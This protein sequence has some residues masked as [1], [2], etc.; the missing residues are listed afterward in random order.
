MFLEGQGT[1]PYHQMILTENKEEQIKSITEKEDTIDPEVWNIE[2]LGLA[3]KKQIEV[4]SARFSD[5]ETVL[6]KMVWIFKLMVI[7]SFNDYLNTYYCI[8]F[9]LYLL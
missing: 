4:L 5:L 3:K 9:N 8:S 7:I 2:I 6:G 1:H